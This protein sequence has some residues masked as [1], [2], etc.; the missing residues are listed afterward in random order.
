VTDVPDLPRLPMPGSRCRNAP[1]AWPHWKVPSAACSCRAC[2]WPRPRGSS[3]RPAA[4]WT[5]AL[6]LLIGIGFGAA[7][8]RRADPHP[9]AAGPAGLGLRRDLMWQ[10]ET[11]IPLSRVQHLDLRR[12]PLSAVPAWPR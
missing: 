7:A 1:P 4:S 2:H 6:G 12:G 9:L 10:L 3:I 11:R 8:G 5:A